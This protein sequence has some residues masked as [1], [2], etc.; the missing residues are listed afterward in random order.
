MTQILMLLSLFS[1][2]ME[3]HKEDDKIAVNI[4]KVVNYGNR[5][6]QRSY[7]SAVKIEVMAEG[8]FYG[9]GSGNYFTYNGHKFILT[10]AH[11]VEECGTL[12]CGASIDFVERDPLEL[13]FRVTARSDRS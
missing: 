13:H 8:E 3:V 11:V 5:G 9:A 6:L 2:D 7:E 1:C 12:F 10:A 4:Q